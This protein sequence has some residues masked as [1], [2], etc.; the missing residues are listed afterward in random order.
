VSLLL[1]L[2]LKGFT[3]CLVNIHKDNTRTIF[4]KETHTRFTNAL[5]SSRDE[6][7]LTA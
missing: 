3:L 5:R 2:C 1:Q 6:A 7:N 4:Y